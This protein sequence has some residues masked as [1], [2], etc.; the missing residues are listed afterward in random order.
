MK[1][2]G[3]GR[4]QL[5]DYFVEY[6]KEKFLYLTDMKYEMH[7]ADGYVLYHSELV[8]IYIYYEPI[9]YEIYLTLS[10]NIH[11]KSYYFDDVLNYVCDGIKRTYL[12]A[13]DMTSIQN[14]INEL[15][16]ALKK[17][18]I[19]YVKADIGAFV[20]A[21]RNIN[22]KREDE[23]LNKRIKIIEDRAVRA[24]H[25]KDYASVVYEYKSIESHLSQTQQKRLSLCK[26]YLNDKSKT[27]TQ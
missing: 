22:Y 18:G 9:S 12:Y 8:D 27:T 19:N 23:L 3:I 1:D 25:N 17:Y 7:L 21:E 4:N 15:S 16:D 14:A 6:T 20:D 13:K 11:N 2:I 10:E 5:Y 24:W 26:K